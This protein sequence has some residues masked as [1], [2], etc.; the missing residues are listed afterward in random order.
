MRAFIVVA[1]ALGACGS[2]A[3]HST[4]PIKSDKIV[5][6][7]GTVGQLEKQGYVQVSEQGASANCG[8][9]CI[10]EGD[11]AIY[12]GRVKSGDPLATTTNFVCDAT[13]RPRTEWPC[14]VI[15]PTRG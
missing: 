4:A 3:N 7:A 2:E 1:L 12:L 13:N 11:S 9:N 15:G 8:P 6:L 5:S 10:V 14:R